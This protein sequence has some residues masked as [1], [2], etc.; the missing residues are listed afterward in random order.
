[1]DGGCGNHGHTCHW[2]YKNTVVDAT[3]RVFPC[4][5]S[6]SPG[7]NLVF[8]R[9][10]QNAE[11]LFN[12]GLYQAAQSF[13]AKEVETS[14]DAP[15]CTRGQWNQERVNIG[16]EEIWRHFHSADAAFFDTRSLEMLTSW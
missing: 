2:L 6:P 12:T 1:M 9:A 4:C 10:D 16:S 5:S 8:G 3:G 14:G 13:F 15:H 11:D 7:A